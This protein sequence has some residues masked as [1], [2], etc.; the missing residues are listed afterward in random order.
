M[1]IDRQAKRLGGGLESR[2]D[3]PGKPVRG[4]R[5]LR[6]IVIADGA[7]PSDR[8]VHP[9]TLAAFIWGGKVRPVPSLRYGRLRGAA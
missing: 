6:G 3:A 8:P 2:V 5:V 4:A 9:P 1:A 7:S